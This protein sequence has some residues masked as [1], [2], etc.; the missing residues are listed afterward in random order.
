M[1]I[2]VENNLRDPRRHRRVDRLLEGLIAEGLTDRRG[3][4]HGNRLLVVRQRQDSGCF[5]SFDQLVFVYLIHYTLLQYVIRVS[6]VPAGFEPAASAFVVRCASHLSYR[7]FA[8]A[9]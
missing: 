6:I 5:A 7:T 3:P 2:R 4:D 1:G 8:F 9:S